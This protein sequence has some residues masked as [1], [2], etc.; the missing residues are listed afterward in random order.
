MTSAQ[1]RNSPRAVELLMRNYRIFKNYGHLK[2]YP[3]FETLVNEVADQERPSGVKPGSAHAFKEDIDYGH[4]QNEVTLMLNLLPLI[5][6]DAR[7]VKP[8]IYKDEQDY[9]VRAFRAE[10]V[11]KAGDRQFR[12]GHL[13]NTIV[14]AGTEDKIAKALEKS[15]GMTNPKPDF[16]YGFKSNQYQPPLDTR[17]RRSTHHLLEVTPGMYAPFFLIEAKSGEGFMSQA[18]NQASRAGAAIVNA[19]RKLLDEIGIADTFGAD[20]RTFVYSATIND[21]VME[22]WVHWAEVL[23]YPDGKKAF[24]HMDH[25]ESQSLRQRGALTVLRRICH[26][27]MDWG[28]LTRRQMLQERFRLLWVRELNV[29]NDEKQRAREKARAEALAQQEAGSPPRKGKQGR[30]SRGG[31][32]RGGSY[33]GGSSR[34]R[35]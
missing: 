12:A 30:S 27:I 4:D 14:N 28:T 35:G 23:A 18:E 9:E 6:K 1:L 24:F 22:F 21:G 8:D 16:T 32:P 33:R 29:E 34:D 5:M 26:N 19:T 11:W 25:I 15:D 13:P 17:V 10:G 31:T 2:K 20:E 3:T 7:S